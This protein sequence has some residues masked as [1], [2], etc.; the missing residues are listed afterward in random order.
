MSFDKNRWVSRHWIKILMAALMIALIAAP[1][2]GITCS[3]RCPSWQWVTIDE[4]TQDSERLAYTFR[5]DDGTRYGLFL[6]QERDCI[7]TQ[8][9]RTCTIRVYCPNTR[10]CENDGTVFQVGRTSTRCGRWQTV[11]WDV[12]PI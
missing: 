8:Q 2:S 6:E 1:A 5:L 3:K 9:Q 11:G 4:F 12:R 10:R 7:T